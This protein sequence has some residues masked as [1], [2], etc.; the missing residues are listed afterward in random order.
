MMAGFGVMPDAAGATLPDPATGE[1]NGTIAL[2]LWPVSPDASRQPLSAEGCEVHLTLSDSQTDET[3]YPCSGWFQPPG[4]GRYLVWLEQGETVSPQ[5]FITFDYLRFRGLGQTILMPMRAA[6]WLRVDAPKTADG[7][8]VRV[9]SLEESAE[10]VRAFDRRVPASQGGVTV[11]VPAGR[12]IA[13]VF[14]S[15]GRARALSRP[16]QVKKGTTR[17]VAPSTPPNTDVLVSLVRRNHKHADACRSS[18]VFPNGSEQPAEATLVAWDRVVAVWYGL[19][20]AE[21][22]VLVDCG[23]SKF[24]K[25]IQL[26]RFKVITIRDELH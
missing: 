1:I 7:A 22:R 23:P 9:L 21:G 19:K 14:D 4:R 17:T 18:I 5:T 24:E 20:S 10:D 3:R 15:T 26:A 11:R 8:T 16:V 2:L 25:E 6:G 12:A 13:G